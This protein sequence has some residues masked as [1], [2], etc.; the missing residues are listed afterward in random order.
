M[1]AQLKIGDVSRVTGVPIPTLCRWLDRR[2]IEPSRRDHPSSG[3][4]DHRTFGRAIINKIAIAKKLIAVGI[5]AGPANAAA[6]MFTDHGQRNR[7]AGEPFAQGR[8][9]LVLRASGPVIINSIFDAEFSE[10][11]A[12]GIAFVALDCGKTVKEIDAILNTTAHKQG[13]KTHYD[14]DS[15]STRR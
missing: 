14:Y 12:D 9:L 2:V 10:L 3:T 15:N 6:S 5:A 1:K 11:A 13:F 4:G 7:A 8:T